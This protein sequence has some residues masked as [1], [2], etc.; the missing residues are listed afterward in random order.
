MSA[1]LGSRRLS[2]QVAGRACILENWVGPRPPERL[3]QVSVWL[4]GQGACELRAVEGRY[5]GRIS[6][7]QVLEAA[8]ALL[9][10]LVQ[11]FALGPLSRRIALIL[12]TLLRLPGGSALLRAWHER[13]R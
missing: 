5:V 11:P 8:P 2:L 7:C 13:R 12:L 10:P 6:G 3:T 1:G 9:E 4:D